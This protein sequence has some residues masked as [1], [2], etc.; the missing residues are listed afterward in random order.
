M[1]I[2]CVVIFIICSQIAMSQ[3]SVSFQTQVNTVCNGDSCNYQ[4]PSILINEVMLTPIV[5]DGAMYGVNPIS[6]DLGEWIELYNPNLCKPVDISCFYLGNNTPDGMSY[7][8]GYR[9]PANTIV[10]AGGFVVIRGVNATPVAPNLLAQNG[11]KTIELIVDNAL[12]NVCIGGGTRLWFP[13]SGGWFAFYNNNGIPQDAISWNSTTNS[14]MS[15][16]PCISSCG[17]CSNAS[18]LASYDNI[19]AANKN[20]MSSLDPAMYA[21][22]SWSRMPDGGTWSATATTNT[23]GNCNS[24]CNTVASSTCTG[25][26]IANVSGGVPPYTFKWNDSQSSVTNAATGLCAGNYC[27]TVTDAVNTIKIACV[28]IIDFV[29]PV[30]FNGDSLFCLDENGVNYTSNF[31]PSGGQLTGN[32]LS[33]F[34]FSPSIAGVGNHTITYYYEDANTCNNTINKIIRVKTVPNVSAVVTDVKCFGL[35]NGSID[36]TTIGGNPIY[37]YAWS[38]TTQTTEDI[39]NLSAAAYQVIVT[40]AFACDDTLSIQVN[41]PSDLISQITP[42]NETCL[43]ACDGSISVNTSGGV[44]PYSYKLNNIS[45]VPTFTPLCANTY[46]IELSDAN[47]CKKNNTVSV[48][49]GIGLIAE[50][51]LAVSICNGSDTML[52]AS[53]GTGYLWD[54]INNSNTAV[55]M[56]SP[57]VTTT[58]HVTVSNGICSAIDSVIVTVISNPIANAGND[59]SICSGNDTILYGNGGGNYNWSPAISLNYSNIQNPNATPIN[60]TTYYLTVVNA[61]GCKAVDS[62]MLFVKPN[63]IAEAGNGGSICQGSSITLTSSGGTSYMWNDVNNS[64]TQ[65]ITVSPTGNAIYTVTITSNGCTNSDNVTVYVN[66]NPIANAGNDITICV[67]S[68]DTLIA[69]GGTS[70]LWSTGE[71]NDSIVVNP[72]VNSKYF[73]TVFNGICGSTDSVNV[74]VSPTDFANAGLDTIICEGGLAFLTA[75]GGDAYL[76]NYNNSINPLITVSPDSSKTYIVTVYLG[77][78]SDEDTVTVLVSPNPKIEFLFKNETCNMGNGWALAMAS[79]ATGSYSYLWQDLNSKAFISDL[80]SGVYSVT[81]TDDTTGCISSADVIIS[82][83]PGPNA[84]F[85]ANPKITTIENNS[86]NFNDISI[87]SINSWNWNLGDNTTCSSQDFSHV[88]KTGVYI[89]ILTVIDTNNCIDVYADT[90]IVKDVLSFYV[91]NAFTP[92][93]D[94]FNAGFGPEGYNVNTADY[95]MNIFDRWGDLIF[96]T[97]DFNEKWNG[98]LFNKGTYKD[99]IEDVYIYQIYV[100]GQEDVIKEYVGKVV[101]LK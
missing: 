68:T 42:V 61:F 27:V 52:T 66:N 96:S 16:A 15:C 7:G 90:I 97:N 25:Q 48:N 60:T 19:P 85:I 51:G 39:T 73:V 53:G 44:A 8:G 10:P 9:I 71:T 87:G 69:T 6:S 45:S 34:V 3:I 89:V 46:T 98:S 18:S 21:G 36:L 88:Y 26:A 75:S 20:Y 2:L 92:N 76:W 31:L 5:G 43:G 86:I 70:Y 100:R 47:G 4:G 13:N 94:D 17:T 81:A 14:C 30:S 74:Y 22:S 101:L 65:S 72:I 82:N 62:V 64:T 67:G 95:K 37:N 84:K 58:Y 40:D 57:S 23:M 56:V 38:N 83:I 99:A 54:D 33:G 55:V 49:S 78:C 12:G 35:T 93:G 1:R 29:P 41:Q 80:V 77:S 32:G 11:G 91:P 24:V 50:A 28:N 63:P 79:G 59:M